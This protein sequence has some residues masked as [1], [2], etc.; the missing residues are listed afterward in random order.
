MRAFNI[1][2]L[3]RLYH[4]ML[5]S[6]AFKIALTYI[7]VS[8]TWI[9]CSDRVLFLFKHSLSD[10]TFLI[11]NS[12]KGFCFVILNGIVLFFLIRH[13]NRQ[14]T[15]SEGEYRE[16][17]NS[18]PNPMW[19][20]DPVSLKFPSVN[21]AAVEAYGYSAQEFL[22]MTIK[23]IKPADDHEELLQIVKR[24][25]SFKRSGVWRHLK[26]D[27]SMIFVDISCHKIKILG[28]D[29][30]IVLARDC[31]ETITNEDKLKQA[32]LSLADEKKRLSDI[33]ELSKIAGWDYFVEDRRLVLSDDMYKVFNINKHELKVDYD[34]F[35]KTI[36]R[37]DLN[38]FLKAARITLAEGSDLDI[39]HRFYLGQDSVRHIRELGKL[40]YRD[41]K[42]Y[43]IRG[44]M[45]DI[46]ELKHIEEE[47]D[48]I[49]S[50]NKKLDNIITKINNMVVI[51]DPQNRITW[52]NRA[53]EDFTGY[54]LDEI[55]GLNPSSFMLG[56][57]NTTQSD[58]ITEA[59]LHLEAFSV[60]M[61]NYTKHKQPYWVN[62]EFTPMFDE[63]EFIGY[64]TV[65]NNITT[66]KEKEDEITKQ[67]TILRDI[68]WLS[69]HEIRRPAAS[70][71]GLMG[72]INSTN[73]PA[74]KDEYLHLLNECTLQLD[75][76]I[77]QINDT[78]NEKLP[79]VE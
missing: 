71:L 36:H 27:G 60:D 33:Q 65:H 67:N 17:Y 7:I 56:P 79:G 61:V 53:Y 28:K 29:A 19:I 26:K 6:S 22:S 23:D 30:M 41:G 44:T 21:D 58:F 68:A 50:E 1:V 48:L 66:R 14:L 40:E 45:Q 43:K 20:Y 16:L 25:D 63:G 74:E 73:N 38:G 39:V 72:L 8:V 57:D 75:Q 51:L 34:L 55:K 3:K 5:I 77:H 52:V 42:P 2:K 4:S 12:G 47:K 78:I 32:N 24:T 69:S 35:L 37:D 18:N 46:T 59:E 13:G 9:F 49:N 15:K 54:G 31:T 70:I 76:I 10:S 62:I 64:I 11:I